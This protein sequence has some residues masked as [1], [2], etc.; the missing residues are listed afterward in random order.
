MQHICH[1]CGQ[2]YYGAGHACSS[3]GATPYYQN[4]PI[5]GRVPYQY[6]D[7]KLEHIIKVLERIEKLLTGF[8]P[9]AKD[10]K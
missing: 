7:N 6:G 1:G 2:V 3:S 4:P 8:Q 5:D 10:E 9:V